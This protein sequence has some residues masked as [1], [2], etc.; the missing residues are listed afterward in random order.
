M[1]AAR[2]DAPTRAALFHLFLAL[3]CLAS[4]SWCVING[5]ASLAILPFLASLSGAIAWACWSLRA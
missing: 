5:K 3:L 2:L 4:A 1:S